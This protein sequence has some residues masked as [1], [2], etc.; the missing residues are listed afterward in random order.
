MKKRKKRGP[1][2]LSCRDGLFGVSLSGEGAV[3]KGW[4]RQE[5]P[6]GHRP[7]AAGWMW[8]P[9]FRWSCRQVEP[10]ARTLVLAPVGR[11]S[12]ISHFVSQAL[13]LHLSLPQAGIRWSGTLEGARV[14]CHPRVSLC[15]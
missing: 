5:G 7:G 14:D 8:G 4:G 2:R 3:V 6:A 15:Q 11:F 10:G 13:L 12:C 1:S 9:A